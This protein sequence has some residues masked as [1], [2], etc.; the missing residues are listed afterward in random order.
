MAVTRSVE[1][2]GNITTEG[3][4]IGEESGRCMVCIRF[5][6]ANL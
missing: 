1:N 4:L 3:I 6:A 5:V 2:R